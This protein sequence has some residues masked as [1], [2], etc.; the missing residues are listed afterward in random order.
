MKHI[1]Y[2]LCTTNRSET[3]IFPIVSVTFVT[4]YL[5]NIPCT[6]PKGL[7]I[8]NG[9]STITSRTHRV[10][11]YLLRTPI[12]IPSSHLVLA[13]VGD[14]KGLE[15]GEGIGVRVSQFVGNS[16]NR[17]RTSAAKLD[18]LLRERSWCPIFPETYI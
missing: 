11:K 1:V 18:V 5:L 8:G 17:E 10:K 7:N 15:G 4:W 9:Q 3:R 6:Q 12:S 2:I 13:L 16:E 14:R